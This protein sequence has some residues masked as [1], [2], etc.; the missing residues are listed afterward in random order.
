MTAFSGEGQTSS[1]FDIDFLT[2]HRLL[3]LPSQLQPRRAASAPLAGPA[4]T[5]WTRFVVSPVN[6]QASSIRGQ[7]LRA[8]SPLTSTSPLHV[9]ATR[10]VRLDVDGGHVPT[11]LRRCQDHLLGIYSSIEGLRP[12]QLSDLVR[13][14]SIRSPQYPSASVQS[15]GWSSGAHDLPSCRK[16]RPPAT[17]PRP[18]PSPE[19][20]CQNV[21]RG[22]G[23]DRA[24]G[25]VRWRLDRRSANGSGCTGST[26]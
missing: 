6:D 5:F 17:E 22:V 23:L 13:L 9:R 10:P 1:I 25:R 7:P 14:S 24:R 19:T 3:L 4:D 11:I 18:H 12:F 15:P 16:A 20:R 21:E 26:C 2:T 8:T